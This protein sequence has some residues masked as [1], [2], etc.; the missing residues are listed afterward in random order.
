MSNSVVE[1]QTKQ[2]EAFLQDVVSVMTEYMNHHTI[3]SLLEESENG[4]KEYYEGLLAGMRRLLVFCEEGLD[5]C[6]VLVKSTPFRKGAA[7]RMLYKIYHQVICEFFTPKNDYWYENSRSAYTGKNAIAFTMT[8]PFSV[9]Q[10]MKSLEGK[11]QAMREELE[12][13]ETDY[14]TKMIQSQ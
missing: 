2:V 10:L 11:F 13:Y 4:N 6:R 9:Q 5:A 8:P 1:N 12:Y 7:E 14:Q 3:I